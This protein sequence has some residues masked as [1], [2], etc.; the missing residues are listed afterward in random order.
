MEL[1]GYDIDVPIDGPIQDARRATD[2]WNWSRG[3]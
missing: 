3:A 2:C 1:H